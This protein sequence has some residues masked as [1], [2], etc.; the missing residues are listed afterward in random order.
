MEEKRMEYRENAMAEPL[1]CITYTRSFARE[2]AKNSFVGREGFSFRRK[3]AE[4]Q[5]T[6]AP[7]SRY[8]AL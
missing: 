2:G 3:L 8:L 6:I 1:W 5:S 7:I 4:S